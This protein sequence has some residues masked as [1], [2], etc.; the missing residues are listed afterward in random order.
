LP[1]AASQVVEDIEAAK[2][3]YESGNRSADTEHFSFCPVSCWAPYL[4]FWR[5]GDGT[6]GVSVTVLSSTPRYE[7]QA[8]RERTRMEFEWEKERQ[9][10]GLPY[11][12]AAIGPEEDELDEEAYD[13]WWNRYNTLTNDDTP[14]VWPQNRQSLLNIIDHL[15]KALP[16]K[17]VRLDPPLLEAPDSA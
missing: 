4:T 6:M 12:P 11:N 14:C 16:V 10:R 9:S 15:K 2:R 13:A 1:L 5:Y 3:V 8:D 7:R 17:E